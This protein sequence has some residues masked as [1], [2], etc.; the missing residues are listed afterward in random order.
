MESA[1]PSMHAGTAPRGLERAG[2]MPPLPSLLIP[3][4]TEA[5]MQG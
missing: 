3:T 4:G 2:V 1:T 5:R